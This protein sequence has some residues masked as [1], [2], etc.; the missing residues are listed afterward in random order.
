MWGMGVLW[1][2]GARVGLGAQ[3]VMWMEMRVPWGAGCTDEGPRPIECWGRV[4]G[5]MKCW[6]W[7]SMEWLDEGWVP[8]V[9]LEVPS[10]MRCWGKRGLCPCPT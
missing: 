4:G 7:A 8:V 3:G 10:P 6:A 5:P 9:G 2:W 1:G